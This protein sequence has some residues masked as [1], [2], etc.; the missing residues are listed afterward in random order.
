MKYI[1]FDNSEMIRSD[2]KYEGS[3][4][5]DINFNIVLKKKLR[6]KLINLLNEGNEVIEPK[7]FVLDCKHTVIKIMDKVEE[8][9][10]IRTDEEIFESHIN[11]KG[12][13]KIED[14]RN[15]HVKS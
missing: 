7:K 2:L 13:K 1:H 10:L 5:N 15:A 9:D 4:F 3:N 8:D 11:C 6:Q 12:F 14:H